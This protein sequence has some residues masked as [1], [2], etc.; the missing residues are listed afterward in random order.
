MFYD[1]YDSCGENV[2]IM[3]QKLIKL[4]NIF[5]T[6][7]KI[8][9]YK[10]NLS[11]LIMTVIFFFIYID[12]IGFGKKKSR[13]I[14]WI[15]RKSLHIPE[16]IGAYVTNGKCIL[17]YGTKLVWNSVKSTFRAPSNRREAVIEDTIWPI[18]RFRFL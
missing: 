2:I 15:N 5:P 18:S 10:H 9:S 13:T 4:N 16:I 3:Y 7:G 1:D 17:G 14:H 11:K 6:N 8:N 12:I